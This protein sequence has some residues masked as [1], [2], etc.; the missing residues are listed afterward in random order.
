[1]QVGTLRPVA[2]R[3][4]AK[5]HT[6]ATH[7]KLDTVLPAALRL[8]ARAISTWSMHLKARRRARRRLAAIIDEQRLAAL[9]RSLV[10]LRTSGRRLAPRSSIA[11]PASISC[12]GVKKQKQV[13]RKIDL[14]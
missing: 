2:A 5:Q 11:E 7:K 14:I 1:M 6:N 9:L 12:G 13:Y 3:K 4:F 8:T 10:R